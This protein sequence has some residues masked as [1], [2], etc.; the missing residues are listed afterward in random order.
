MFAVSTAV[1]PSAYSISYFRLSTMGLFLGIPNGLPSSSTALLFTIA[2]CSP[3]FSPL[4][5]PSSIPTYG[6]LLPNSVA[7]VLST[8]FNIALTSFKCLLSMTLLN[9][10]LN[11]SSFYSRQSSLG[12]GTSCICPFRTLD[13]TGHICSNFTSKYFILALYSS[14]CFSRLVILCTVVQDTRMPDLGRIQ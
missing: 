7:F 4:V 8:L 3:Y 10:S 14:V 11:S 1:F 12:C 5:R 9:Y 13:F 2:N 6:S